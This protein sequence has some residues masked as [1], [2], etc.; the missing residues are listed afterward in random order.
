MILLLINSYSRRSYS[1]N[2]IFKYG[3]LKL[4]LNFKEYL[5]I[6]FNTGRGETI[7]HMLLWSAFWVS[8]V[9]SS[10]YLPFNMEVLQPF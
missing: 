3:H 4:T 6:K 9:L 1:S 5:Y 2:Y 10:W 7:L 8:T